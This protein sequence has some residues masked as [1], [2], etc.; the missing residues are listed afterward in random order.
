MDP[1]DPWAIPP[2]PKLGDENIETTYASVG[3]ALSSWEHFE[4]HL[5]LLFARFITRE[6]DSLA[7]RRA[8]G[9]VASFTGRSALIRDAA[10]AYFAEFPDRE[11]SDAFSEQ[12]KIAARAS[13]RRNDIAHG[14]VQPSPRLS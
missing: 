11:L 10:A 1:N 2:T 7:A 8:Y 4:A 5:A 6:Q 12:L 14:I 13:A 3:R 9:T